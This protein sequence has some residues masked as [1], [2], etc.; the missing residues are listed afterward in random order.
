MS[1]TSPISSRSPSRSSSRTQQPNP[2]GVLA[3][4]SAMLA[5]ANQ[6]QS[7]QG[8]KSR[9]RP[10]NASSASV[11]DSPVPAM[12][13]TADNQDSRPE[14]A[15]ALT[16]AIAQH[17]SSTAASPS[18]SPSKRTRRRRAAKG[19]PSA[20]DADEVSEVVPQL[21]ESATD[22]PSA[23]S[24]HS[25][26]PRQ[27]RGLS[28]INLDLTSAHRVSDLNNDSRQVGEAIDRMSL[29][30]SAPA[31][32]FIEGT[33][34]RKQR[35]KQIQDDSINS[36]H[37]T[38]RSSNSA[39]EWEMPSASFI[40]GNDSLTWQQAALSRKTSQGKKIPNS[41]TSNDIKPNKKHTP[42]PGPTQRA[43]PLSASSIPTGTTNAAAAGPPTSQQTPTPAVSGLTWQQAMLQ[44][45]AP[46][47]PSYD[48]FEALEP[49][50]DHSRTRSSPVKNSRPFTRSQQ[51]SV[52][53]KPP[54]AN[55]QEVDLDKQLNDLVLSSVKPTTKSIQP[56]SAK[57]TKPIPISATTSSAPNAA[58]ASP[59]AT[60]PIPMTANSNSPTKSALYAGPKFHN[61]PHAAQLPTP[62][63][64]AFLNKNRESSPAAQSPSGTEA[65]FA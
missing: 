62:R 44:K 50:P 35:S 65:I 48:L 64:A 41:K 58:A 45:S 17:A 16:A 52:P 6:S 30:K 23:A 51:Q 61:S 14:P 33:Q 60:R 11:V 56:K 3:I 46:A 28:S 24:K 54:A 13:P 55:K 20:S 12:S 32:S 10:Q 42:T 57:K 59:S 38:I 1:P 5:N 43:P 37:P 15:S 2:P 25:S 47:T 27:D 53:S 34:S 39:D 7:G 18:N 9:S 8:K 21:G 29:S 26:R 49:V 40:T 22:S 31:S 63:L 36:I 19:P 4:S